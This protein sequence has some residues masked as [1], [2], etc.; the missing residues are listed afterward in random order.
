[1]RQT[2]KK[3][4]LTTTHRHRWLPAF[5]SFAQN[6]HAGKMLDPPDLAM[7]MCTTMDKAG[8]ITPLHENIFF[9]YSHRG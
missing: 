6:F 1:L 7:A 3:R 5:E 9:Q 8:T 2:Q 4:P